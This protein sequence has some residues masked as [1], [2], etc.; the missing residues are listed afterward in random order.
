MQQTEQTGNHI[1]F[2]PWYPVKES[3]SV[4][5]V[6]FWPYWNNRESM[7]RDEGE[8]RWLDR[9][10]ACYRNHYDEPVETITMCSLDGEYASGEEADTILRN[11]ANALI[12]SVV[13]P[14][15]VTTIVKEEGE[16]LP[17]SSDFFELFTQIVNLESDTIS[18][19][20]G[21]L[22]SGG[23][24]KGKV[25]FS[26]PWST[27]GHNTS[28]NNEVLGGL[29]ILLEA[30]PSNKIYERIFRSLE[31]FRLAHFEGHQISPWSKVVMMSTAFETL[32]DLPGNLSKVAFAGQVEVVINNKDFICHEG[33]VD[34]KK[35]NLQTHNAV[36]WWAFHFYGLRSEI[37]HGNDVLPDKFPYPPNSSVNQLMVADLV[38]YEILI[39]LLMDNNLVG[40]GARAFQKHIDSMFNEASSD[41]SIAWNFLSSNLGFNRAHERLGWINVARK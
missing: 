29:S 35:K 17:P 40:D 28:T 2:M 1:S 4:G 38:F 33:P 24:R 3:F 7:V 15:I 18:V 31:W 41:D 16:W 22:I 8:R 21:C 39:R 37:V 25:R 32:L 30:G 19:K 6:K 34:R 26:M 12:F 13:A 14:N 27:G 9:Y 23:N 10:F 5:P 11:A 20:A 36:Y